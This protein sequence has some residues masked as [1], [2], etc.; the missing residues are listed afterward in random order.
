MRTNRLGSLGS[1]FAFVGLLVPSAAASTQGPVQGGET[2]DPGRQLLSL[3]GPWE[4]LFDPQNAGREAAWQTLSVFSANPDREPIRVPSCWEEIRRDYEGVAFYGRRFSVPEGWDHKA[5]RLQ[6]DAVNYVAEVWLNDRVVGRHEGGYGPFAFRVED[7][8]KFDEENFLALRVI[9]PIVAER[10]VID[11]IG[12]NDMPHWRGAIAGGIWQS[13]RLIATGTA[14]VDDVF[15]EP[16]LEDDSVAV[17]LT[18][19]NAAFVGREAEV[20]VSIRPVDQPERVAAEKTATLNLVPGRT[21]KRWTLSLPEA[22]YWSPDDPYRYRARIRVAEKS[23]TLDVEEVAFGMR[24]L[25]IRDQRF[26]LNGKPIYIKAAFFEALYPT[27]LAYPDSAEMAGREIRLAKEAGFNMIRPWRKPPPPMW[28]DLCDEMG[29]MVI[30]GMPIECMQRWPTVTPHLR[31]RIENEVRSAVLR[32]R[33][34]ACIVQWEIFNEILRADLERLKHPASMLARRLDPTRLI[35]DESGGFAGG[36]NI[37]LPY[38]FEPEVFNDVHNYPGAPLNDAS[39]DKFLALSRTPEEIEAMGLPAGR[40]GTSQTTPGR[41][42]VVSEIGYGSLPDL[43]DNNRRFA[44]GGN[45]LVPP[46]RYHRDLAQSFR[47]VLKESGMDAVYPDLHKF[48]LD[49]QAIHSCG[50]KRMIEAIR[51]NPRVGGYAVHALTGGDWVLGAGLLDLFRNPKGSYQGTKEANRPRYLALRVRPRNVYA[52]RGAKITVTGINDLAEATG[53][54]TVDLLSADGTSPFRTEKKASLVSGI[55]SLF[56]EP[57]DA[58]ELAGAYT[59]RARL[60]GEDGSVLAENAATVDVFTDEQFAV[61]AAKIAV[62]DVNNSLRP[63]LDARGAAYEE[64]GPGTPKTL[65]VFV[66]KPL[67]ENPQAKA[68]FQSL[69]DFVQAGGTAV[70]L[71]TVQRWPANPFWGGKLPTEEALPLRPAFQR[72]VGLWV[73]VSHIV[74]DHPVFAGLPTKCMMGQVYENV[75]ATQTLMGLEG[76]LIVG[77]V[78]H[79]WNRGDKDAQN[80]LGPASAWYGMDLG[81]VPYGKGRYVL[82]ALRIVEN[83]GSDPVADKILF[84]LIRWTTVER[85]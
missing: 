61:P 82:S 3:D 51:S 46:Y 20:A 8:L 43:V 83:L 36:S 21:T 64:F 40:L 11:G 58:R 5:V 12:Q 34:R 2:T 60:T 66:S 69:H 14:Y 79:D 23:S 6:F 25:T 48:C 71:E 35:L 29:V 73:G 24:E 85:P 10:K 27:R 75:W 33:N 81:V 76:E 78:S 56:E 72:A 32:D 70:Y 38:Q 45:P 1:I 30:G 62:L 53:T 22:R 74:T 49:Q 26:E 4:I 42:T 50:N 28:L 77:S 19:E 55:S 80:Y 9:G 17:H 13:V 63:F 15:L 41:L 52:S 47:D 39:Y 37:Y 31:D 67:A 65:P 7:L 57:L 84:N 59:A 68:R 18:L 54:L 44:E 16:R